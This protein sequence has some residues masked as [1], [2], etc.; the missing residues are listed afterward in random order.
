MREDALFKSLTGSCLK[1]EMDP[2]LDNLTKEQKKKFM[3]I[4]MLENKGFEVNKLKERYTQE[5][6]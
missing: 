3:H 4:L 2:S 6:N 1:G 5:C